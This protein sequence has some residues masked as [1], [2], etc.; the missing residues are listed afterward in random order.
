MRAVRY[1]MPGGFSVADMPVPRPGPGDALV[2][3]TAAGVCGTDLHIHDGDF[4]ASFPL[5]PGHEMVGVVQELGEGADDRLLGQTVAVNGNWGCGRCAF[6]AAGDRLLCRDLVAIGVTR[7]GGFGEYVLAPAGQCFLVGDL[8]ADVSVMVEPTACAVHGLDVLGMRPSADALVIGAG[9]TGLILAQLL[10][11]NGAARVTT[12]GP[13]AFKLD[14]ARALGIDGTVLLPP[15]IESRMAALRER[16]PDGFDVVVDATG[17]AEVSAMSVRLAKDGGTV[18]WYGVM[19]P[20]D[21]AAVSPYEV[22]R[23][24]LSIKGSFAQVECFSRAI[25]ALRSGRVKTTGIIT[26]RFGL[27]QFGDCLEVVR[28][29]RSCLKAIIEI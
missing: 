28:S 9:P 20:E 25:A 2:R 3:M 11:H 10:M 24:Q 8:T 21:M 1:E 23:R 7:D 5:T 12:A 19:A 22:Y 14:V 27:D 16:A 18:L 17:S 29:D 13:T 4:F 6:C 15:D 26:H